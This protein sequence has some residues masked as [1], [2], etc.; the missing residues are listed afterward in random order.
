[1]KQVHSLLVEH[2][3]PDCKPELQSQFGKPGTSLL[4]YNR[5]VNLPLP[6]VPLLHKSLHQDVLWAQKNEVSHFIH[7][8]P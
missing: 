5:F 1:M 7:T 4:L 2:C 3:P 6:L 8:Q